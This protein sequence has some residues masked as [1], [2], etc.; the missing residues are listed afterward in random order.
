[1]TTLLLK[2]D[3]QMT[4]L[5]LKSFDG[6]SDFGGCGLLALPEVVT[7]QHTEGQPPFH[8]QI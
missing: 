2:S 5:L 1:M 3:I 4:D 8:M 6:S 7:S